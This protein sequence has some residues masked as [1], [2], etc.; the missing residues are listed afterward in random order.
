MPP[1]SPSSQP[2]PNPALA[3][4]ELAPHSV[5]KLT[6]SK[7]LMLLAMALVAVAVPVLMGEAQLVRKGKAAGTRPILTPAAAQTAIEKEQPMAKEDRKS[8]RLNSSHRR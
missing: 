5:R 4:P 7:N 2:S 1:T 3:G 6:L 8:T